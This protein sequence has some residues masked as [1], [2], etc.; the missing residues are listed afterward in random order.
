MD[1]DAPDGAA[2]SLSDLEE[3]FEPHDSGLDLEEL[4][5]ADEW[6]S[7]DEEQD[8]DTP[9]SR[10]EMCKELDEMMD[11]DQE[12]SLWDVRTYI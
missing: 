6:K 1:V 3:D 10:E 12:S 7:F 8:R 4:P 5:D 9:I 11:A 2:A